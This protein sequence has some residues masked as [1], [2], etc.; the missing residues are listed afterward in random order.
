MLLGLLVQTIPQ[1]ATEDS[2]DGLLRVYPPDEDA[3]VPAGLTA[4]YLTDP[5]G[6][7][8]AGALAAAD[9]GQSAASVFARDAAAP[10]AAAGGTGEGTGVLL[11]GPAAPGGE[12]AIGVGGSAYTPPPIAWRAPD[13]W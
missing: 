3:G 4:H 12:F 2:P 8:P 6:R 7:T 9:D 1:P 11:A 10:R 13:R 5:D